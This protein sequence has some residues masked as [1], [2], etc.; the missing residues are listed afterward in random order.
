V[1]LVDS[2]A[3]LDM[4]EDLDDVLVRMREAGVAGCVTIGVDRTSSRW[5][6][7]TARARRD[8]WATVGL[9]PHDAKDWTPELGAELDSLAAEDRV[10]GV[11]EA[12]LDYYYDSSPRATQREVFSW[13][14]DLAR[15]VGKTLVIHC[16]DAFDDLFAILEAAPPPPIVFHCWSGGPSQAERALA[17]GAVLSFAGTVTFKNA[18]P[19]RE[20]ARM[21]PL[22]RLLVETDAPFLTPVPLRG[23]RNEPAYVRHTAE[24]LAELKAVDSEELAAA[25]TRTAEAVFGIATA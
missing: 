12:G 22:D 1:T 5:A 23:R 20:A 24:F 14:L 25:S 6:V 2:H 8:V 21:V 19:V 7:R 9:H 15:R 17:L 11:G 10:V 18:E 4:L 16:R 13:H 3:H